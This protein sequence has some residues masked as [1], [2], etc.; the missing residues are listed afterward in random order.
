MYVDAETKATYFYN[1]SHRKVVMYVLGDSAASDDTMSHGT[2]CA[3]V[4]VGACFNASGP[5]YGT[6]GFCG[7]AR[8]GGGEWSAP[9]LCNGWQRALHQGGSPG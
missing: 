8:Q 6:G 7:R 4:A 2:H 9:R 3:G 5:D 1:P